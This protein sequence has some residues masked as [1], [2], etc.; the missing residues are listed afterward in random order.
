MKTKTQINF[1]LA[2][3]CHSGLHAKVPQLITL[4]HRIGLSFLADVVAIAA[5]GSL[6]DIK[7][8]AR[9]PIKHTY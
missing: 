7:Y 8:R 1:A 6:R 4:L 5:I 9:I 3:D 2:G